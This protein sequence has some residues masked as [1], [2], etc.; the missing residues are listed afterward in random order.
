MQKKTPTKKA[1]LR[2]TELGLL[3]EQKS[4]SFF[5][6][7][8]SKRR[9][10]IATFLT[11]LN[12]LKKRSIGFQLSCQSDAAGEGGRI[13]VPTGL[14]P[15]T[16]VQE[17]KGW[18]CFS[19]SQSTFCPSTRQ[20]LSVHCSSVTPLA[21]CRGGECAIREQREAWPVCSLCSQLRGAE[22]PC[23]YCCPGSVSVGEWQWLQNILSMQNRAQGCHCRHQNHSSIAAQLCCCL[24]LHAF[25]S[26]VLLHI[27]RPSL[28][29]H[30]EDDTDEM[31]QQNLRD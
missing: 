27:H 7:F 18:A 3:S 24:K 8:N 11:P 22:T 23:R 5:H 9:K 13:A 19:H 16:E 12:F 30:L 14:W 10:D 28:R 20:S 6:D 31:I 29:P 21:L 26:M 25:D 4:I 2:I 17:D 1:S 15:Y